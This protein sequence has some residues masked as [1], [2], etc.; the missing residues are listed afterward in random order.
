MLVVDKA[1]V[2]NSE[3]MA[4]LTASD[5]A[6]AVNCYIMKDVVSAGLGIWFGLE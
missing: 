5:V 4:G 3:A 6:H 1:T 2:L